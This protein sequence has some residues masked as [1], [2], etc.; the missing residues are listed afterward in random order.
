MRKFV[1]YGVAALLI[2]CAVALPVAASLEWRQAAERNQQLAGSIRTDDW[3]GT[4]GTFLR[5]CLRR[6]DG[7]DIGVSR[8]CFLFPYPLWSITIAFLLAAAAVALII[9]AS[10]KM[11]KVTLPLPKVDTRIRKF[12]RYGVGALLIVCAV[13]LPVAASQ[14]WRVAAERNQYIASIAGLRSGEMERT[15]A[16]CCLRTINWSAIG[17]RR[18]CFIFPYPLWSLIASFLLS[19]AAVKVI[20][21]TP[22]DI[23]HSE[24]DPEFYNG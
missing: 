7:R 12:M 24:P 5:C 21:H 9:R 10:K 2:V 15:F 16:R 1:H 6:I 11:T 3:Q 20:L 17:V 13:V 8:C 4:F 18:C 22:T 19:A 14:R 23:H